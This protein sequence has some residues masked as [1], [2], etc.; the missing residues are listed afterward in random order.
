MLVVDNRPRSRIELLAQQVGAEAPVHI[1]KIHKVSLIQQ[2]D[3]SE[4]ESFPPQE[5]GTKTGSRT[6]AR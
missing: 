1:L 4:V 2:A 6:L 5:C 3:L